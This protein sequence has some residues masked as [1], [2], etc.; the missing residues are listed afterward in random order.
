MHRFNRL[1][2]AAMIAI[3]ALGAPATAGAAE[4]T[5]WKSVDLVLHGEG[6]NALLIVGGELP[7]TVEL[8]A[9]VELAAPAGYQLAW[10]GEILGGP[11]E[12]DP[13]VTYEK[14]IRGASDVYTFTLTQSRTAQLEVD[15][16]GT[17]LWDGSAYTAKVAWTAPW[18]VEA[19]N[20]SVRVPEGAQVTT[21]AEGA[22]MTPGP[23]G[24]S[25]YRRDFTDVKA[26]DAPSLLFSYTAPAGA[27]PASGQGAAPAGD[28]GVAATIA[29]LLM[30]GA[31]IVVG[32]AVW[33][34]MKGTGTG[35]S[36]D[37]PASKASDRKP[38]S[39]PAATASGSPGAKRGPSKTLV[40]A[41][42]VAGA[43]VIGLIIAASGS[44]SGNVVGDTVVMS[45]ATVDECA[46]A[47]IPLT[48]PPGGELAAD[49]DKIL[50]SLRPLEGIGRATVYLTQS[51][52]SVSYCQ[53]YIDEAQIRAALAPTGYVQA[54]QP[55]PAPTPS[56]PAT[57]AAPAPTA[58]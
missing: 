39:R 3:L 27:T 24:Y 5:P 9:Q 1:A 8:P 51:Y 54:G 12:A 57:G 30:I 34:R 21:V 52:I 25:Y 7:E 44:S 15:A 32:F 48:A 41:A 26:G 55:V 43:L 2:I 14:E 4:V 28:G 37:V 11:V 40:M 6:A 36:P 53:S 10:I 19:M 49:A 29:A 38:A 16:P 31:L 20:I 23:P 45:Y 42:V 58:P 56:A 47:N 50:Q 46:E 35:D 22:Q 17:I 13:A 33:R 18:D